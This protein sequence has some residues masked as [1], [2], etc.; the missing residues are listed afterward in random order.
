MSFV[1]KS[2]LVRRASLVAAAASFASLAQAAPVALCGFPQSPTRDA[3]FR[4]AAAVFKQ[5]GLA[6]R[7]IDLQSELGKRAASEFT[8]AQLL[9]TKCDV[10]V[11]VPMASADMQFKRGVAVSAPYMTASFVKFSP[12]ASSAAPGRGG[13][14]AVAYESPAQLIAAEEKDGNFDVEN[15]T[16]AVI[17]AVAAG[18]ARSGIVW[19]PSLVAYER[20]HAG[21]HFDV[22]PTRTSIS[23]WTLRFVASDAHGKLVSDISAAIGRLSRSGEL[24][25]ITAPWTPRPTAAAVPADARPRL[26]P[27]VYHPSAAGPGVRLIR[28]SEMASATQQ[29]NFAEG[30]IAPGKKLYAAECAQCHGDELQGHTAPALRGP[31]F[32]PATNSTMTIGGIYQYMTTNMPAD[33]PGKL[34]PNEYVNIMAYLLHANGY[35]PSGRKM[36][37]DSAGDDQSPF[38]SYVK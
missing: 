25:D 16:A 30:Q 29:A 18:K 20:S 28:V 9:K 21:V 1:L 31:G 6:Y 34:K 37:P 13:S 2:R 22:Q 24:R 7:K 33:K 3:D 8:I 19:Y 14:V 5:L 27:A 10:F 35:G 15:T 26:Q 32:A 12:A 4:V 11:G 38:N 17:D 36:T 23:N